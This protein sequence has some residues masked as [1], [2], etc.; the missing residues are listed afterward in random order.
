MRQAYSPEIAQEILERF[1]QKG[2]NL[3]RTDNLSQFGP[4]ETIRQRLAESL[5]VNG[6][7]I[8]LPVADDPRDPKQVIDALEVLARRLNREMPTIRVSYESHPLTGITL[9]E[10]SVKIHT[11]EGT[12]VSYPVFIES[13]ESVVQT[14]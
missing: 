2:W 8:L 14:R 4:D 9:G 5:E 12:F 7:Y 11:P 6:K 13:L 10:D 1:H 3:Y